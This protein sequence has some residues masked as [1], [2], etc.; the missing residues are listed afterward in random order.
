VPICHQSA[1]GD[2]ALR[3]GEIVNDPSGFVDPTDATEEQ[4]GAQRDEAVLD[5]G[6]E[7]DGEVHK[8]EPGNVSA[9]RLFGNRTFANDSEH[10]AKNTRVEMV[11]RTVR[12]Q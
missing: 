8:K 11:R 1:A 5:E 10:R 7:D 2:N 6:N 3:D 4:A 12:K 9:T